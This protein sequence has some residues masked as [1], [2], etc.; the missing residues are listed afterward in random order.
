[1]TSKSILLLFDRVENVG[2]S[3]HAFSAKLIDHVEWA[4]QSISYAFSE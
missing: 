4:G 1:M 3:T 2:S